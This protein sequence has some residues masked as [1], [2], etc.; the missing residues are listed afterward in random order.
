MAIL[1]LFESEKSHDEATGGAPSGGTGMA[2][3]GTLTDLGVLLPGEEARNGHY[4]PANSPG[5]G[6]VFYRDKLA[7]N[8]V[9][10]VPATDALMAD[11]R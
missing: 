9:A 11:A 2:D 6:L 7:A 4:T 10:R 5:H 3:G 8:T 1:P